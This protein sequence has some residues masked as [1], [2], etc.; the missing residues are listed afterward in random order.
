MNSKTTVPP[1]VIA[2]VFLAAIFIVLLAMRATSDFLAPIL[3]AMVLAV[4]T[5]PV[6][7]WFMD[8]GAPHWLALTLTIAIDVVFIVIIVWLVSASV[9][10]FSDT[11]SEYEQRFAEIEQSL[12]GLL[13]KLGVDEDTLA[14]DT[15]AAPKGLLDLAAGFAAGIVSGLSNWGTIVL[16]GIFFLVEAMIMPRKIESVTQKDDP[17]V[18]NIFNLTGGLREYMVINAG[19]GLLAAVI[20][21]I[22]LAVMGIEFAVLWGILS[23]F[24]SFVPNVG[25]IISVIPPAIMALIQFGPTEM[26]IVIGAYI[27]INTLVDNVIKPHFIEEGVNISA[28]VS[29]VSL[30]VW[31][32]VL[33]PLG[34]ILAVPMAIIIQFVFDS[35]EE[36]RWLA[37]MMGSGSEPFNPETRTRP[38]R[39]GITQG[40]PSAH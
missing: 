31:G 33:G 18:Q 37:Y 5:T 27:L 30:I 2:T 20:N 40:K 15:T 28:T 7:Y 1:L 14:A 12:E 26:L 34:A 25:F 6:L 21:T 38:R 13:D 19:V 29:F 10:G 35:R 36:T 8:K 39:V 22:L 11:L 4:C 24:F 3:L 32:W 9:Q 16:T 23:F 17:G